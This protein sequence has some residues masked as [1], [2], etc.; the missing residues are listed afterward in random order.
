MNK[1]EATNVQALIEWVLALNV[2]EIDPTRSDLP[3][4]ELTRIVGVLA[5]RSHAALGAGIGQGE[6]ITGAMRI[7]GIAVRSSEAAS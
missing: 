1:S 3:D 2:F 7:L 5:D 6:A 4:E